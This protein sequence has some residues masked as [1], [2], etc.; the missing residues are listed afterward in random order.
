MTLY[1]A[2]DGMLATRKPTAARPNSLFIYNAT[3]ESA[4]L[5]KQMR[6]SLLFR[7]ANIRRLCSN[8]F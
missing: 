2:G 3:G 8:I 1:A 6:C 4:S 7:L 5:T